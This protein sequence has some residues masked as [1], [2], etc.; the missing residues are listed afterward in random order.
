M[1]TQ[2]KTARTFFVPSG[3]KLRLNS[4]QAASR[5]HLLKPLGGDV[6]EVLPD[7]AACFKRGEIIGYD[8][9]ALTKAQ[10]SNNPLEEVK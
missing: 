6:Y 3:I 7:S 5:H 10:R 9:A 8:L 2:V 4:A 1:Y